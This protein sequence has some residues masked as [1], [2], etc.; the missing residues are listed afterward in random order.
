MATA[1]FSYE[2]DI[3]PLRGQNF[4]GITAA[5]L[6][7]QAELDKRTAL[8]V[9]QIQ[10]TAAANARRE[11]IAF[12]Q[13]QMQLERDAQQSRME[14]EALTAMP[15]LT[16]QLTGILDDPTKD[17]AT[18]AA[19]AARLKLQNAELIGSSKNIGNLFS[20]FDQEIQT[21]KVE[22]SQINSLATA[23]AQAGRPDA[24][25][26]IYEGKQIPFANEVITAADEIAKAKE[27]ER[28]DIARFKGAEETGKVSRAETRLKLDAL[29]K[30]R[31]TLLGMKPESGTLP[32]EGGGQFG[33]TTTGQATKF[34]ALQ[35]RT[36]ESMYKRLN[37]SARK[38]DLSGMTDERF[39]E[40]Y[41]DTLE[42]TLSEID[43]LSGGISPKSTISEKSQ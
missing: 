24:V 13:Q 3:A 43:E 14:R 12:K 4:G 20:A 16:Q 8:Q 1:G 21:R 42:G 17:D 10:E 2:K 19:E 37:P 30:Q 33:A 5:G 32:T 35:K 36:L 9:I 23:L 39:L 40:L 6:D 26:K 11:E 34:S 27:Q 41:S 28:E 25:R 15:A 38:K 22:S 18:K 7:Y 29:N 31:E